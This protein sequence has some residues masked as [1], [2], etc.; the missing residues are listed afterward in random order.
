MRRSGIIGAVGKVA[1]TLACLGLQ[2][3]CSSLTGGDGSGNVLANL[4]LF[5]SSKQPPASP[6]PGAAP[7]NVDCP[8][9][10]V[11][12]GTSAVRVYAGSDQ[13]NANLRYQFSL[14]DTARDCQ[15]VD[16]KLNI[17]V[18]VAGRVLI[19]PAG[20]PPSFTV[21]VRIAI[22][23]EIDGQAAV[24]Q[25]YRV[26][27]TISPG[28]TTTAF[29]LVSDPPLS[30]PFLHQDSDR[31]Y[32]ILVGFDQGAGPEKAKPPVKRAKRS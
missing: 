26:A 1:F 27:A 21:P 6:T 2:A 32:T 12:D 25:L 19:G 3:G 7:V 10:E 18:G 4:V 23:R 5:N 29:T 17:K 30:V 14:G 8:Q 9:I 15:L 24:S 28:E 13:S 11:Q 22:R 31:D 16:G 20:A